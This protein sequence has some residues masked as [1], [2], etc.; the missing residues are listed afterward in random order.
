MKI[1]GAENEVNRLTYQPVRFRIGEA[2]SGLIVCATVGIV[3]SL[4]L[5]SPWGYATALVAGVAAVVVVHRASRIGL[6]VDTHGVTIRNYWTEHHLSWQDIRGVGI[7]VKGVLPQPAFAFNLR[8]GRVVFAQATPPRQSDRHEL[9]AAILA[10]APPEVE[11]LPDIAAKFGI[12]SDR[13]LTAR[14]RLWWRSR[15]E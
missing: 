11:A 15:F 4:A 10:L 5:G 7:A 2:W 1:E 3:V 13:A 6:F 12:G 14:L 8:S 9:R